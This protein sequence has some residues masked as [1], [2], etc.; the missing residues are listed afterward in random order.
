[1]KLWKQPFTR[2]LAAG[3]VLGANFISARV[4]MVHSFAKILKGQQNGHGKKPTIQ[5]WAGRDT[6]PG[7]ETKPKGYTLSLKALQR[8]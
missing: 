6:T 2:T 5:G 7:I 3:F 1:M 8:L 4:E